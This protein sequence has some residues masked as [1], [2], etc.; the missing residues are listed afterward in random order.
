MLVDEVLHN[1]A[2]LA[3]DAHTLVLALV[4]VISRDEVRVGDQLGTV[5]KQVA[6]ASRF[7]NHCII[8]KS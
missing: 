6:A 3:A 2:L 4:Q 8:H 1:F 5:V 7:T